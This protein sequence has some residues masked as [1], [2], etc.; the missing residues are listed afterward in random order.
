[1]IKLEVPLP[2][3]GEPVPRVVDFAMN[4]PLSLGLR[5]LVD[6]LQ[7]SRRDLRGVYISWPSVKREAIGARIR[8]C[9]AIKRQIHACW[10]ISRM[11]MLIGA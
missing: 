7:V 1:M 3:F 10:R 4:E 6:Q 2:D 11:D 8:A 5:D 9:L